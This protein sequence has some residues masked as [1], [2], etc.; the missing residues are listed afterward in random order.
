MLA[1]PAGDGRA[2]WP[3]PP[4]LAGWLTS[5]LG[6]PN[7]SPTAS[8]PSSS[9]PVPIPGRLERRASGETPP[10]VGVPF[11]YSILYILSPAVT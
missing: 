3:K 5:D 8:P 4:A 9:R 2:R 7:N 11:L 10:S 1:D 6:V